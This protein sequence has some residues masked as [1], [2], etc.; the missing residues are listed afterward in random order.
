MP[1]FAEKGAIGKSRVR[2]DVPVWPEADQ[3]IAFTNVWS[4]GQ[5]GN[6]WLARS[7]SHFDPNQNLSVAGRNG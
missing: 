1:F 4:Q 2:L 5:S 6:H 3:Q 7:L